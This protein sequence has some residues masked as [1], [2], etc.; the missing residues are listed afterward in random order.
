MANQAKITMLNANNKTEFELKMNANNK[1]CG[2]Q[3]K[4]E[5]IFTS[6]I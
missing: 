2:T 3:R 6:A 1:T 4:K 5:A